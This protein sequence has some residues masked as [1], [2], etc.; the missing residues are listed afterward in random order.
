MSLDELCPTSLICIN[1][2]SPT[3]H[4]ADNLLCPTSLFCINVPSPT[5]HQADNLRCLTS[6]FCINVPSPTYHPAENLL[7]LTSLFCINVPSPTYQQVEIKFTVKTVLSCIQEVRVKV[8]LLPNTCSHTLIA[9]A[10]CPLVR[11]Q[12]LY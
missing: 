1:V 5:Y 12:D 7:C 8:C 6:L 10:G 4:Q 2:P 11:H 3:Y 9:E